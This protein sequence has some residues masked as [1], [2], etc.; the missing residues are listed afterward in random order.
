VGIFGMQE[1]ANLVG[2]TLQIDSAPGVG[3]EV[4]ITIPLH[5]QSKPS[6]ARGAVLAA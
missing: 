5:A 2:G 3:T 4:R 1:R 6:D